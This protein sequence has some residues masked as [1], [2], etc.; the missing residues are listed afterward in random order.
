MTEY[1]QGDLSAPD[2]REDTAFLAEQSGLP[3]DVFAEAFGA[4]WQ[5]MLDMPV[6]DDAEPER[7]G[8]SFGGWFVAG[9][10]FQI[11]LRPADGGVELGMPV[12]RRIGHQMMWQVHRREYVPTVDGGEA[13]KEALAR[14]L[15]ARRSSFRYCRYCRRVTPPEGRTE[16]DVCHGC[17][18][19][20]QG[21]VY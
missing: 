12:G 10:P 2:P 16:V 5:P 15:K 20:W 7:M 3:V 11:C 14:L 9:D 8:D 6:D 18:S 17:A 4:G 21:A 1:K 13:G 19:V